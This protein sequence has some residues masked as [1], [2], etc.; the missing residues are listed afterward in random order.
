MVTLSVTEA[1]YP[2]IKEV[3]C[4]ILFVC[5]IFIFIGVFLNTSLQRTLIALELYYYL[6]THTKYMQH[7][8]VRH[9]LI[10]D[11]VEDGKSKIN[12]VR[13]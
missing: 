3:C 2:E 8:E 6:I 11:Y 9:H 1:E 7:I 4:E 5:A 12:S 13:L 10:Q